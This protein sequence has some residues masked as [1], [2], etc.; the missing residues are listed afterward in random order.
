MCHQSDDVYSDHVF[1]CCNNKR[2]IYFKPNGKFNGE[3]FKINAG[4]V[5]RRPPKDVKSAI[6]KNCKQDITNVQ[7]ISNNLEIVV[8]LIYTFDGEEYRA[9]IISN[10][11]DRVKTLAK[12]VDKALITLRK[13]IDV[14]Y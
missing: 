13:V 7:L 10:Y 9:P 3:E 14:I 8:G 4:D 12:K 11:D 1:D 5:T 6:L 2:L